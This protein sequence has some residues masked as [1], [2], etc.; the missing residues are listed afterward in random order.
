[1]R[2][3]T[4]IMGVSLHILACPTGNGDDDMDWSYL[5][6]VVHWRCGVLRRVDGRKVT[7]D[8]QTLDLRGTL[9]CVRQ[10]SAMLGLVSS[11]TYTVR[12]SWSR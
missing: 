6:A 2:A 4:S 9:V 10:R 3:T 11:E 7:R 1:M 5:I 8:D 12:R